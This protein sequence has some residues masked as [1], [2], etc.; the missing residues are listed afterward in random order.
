MGLGRKAI[1]EVVAM[2]WRINYANLFYKFKFPLRSDEAKLQIKIIYKS[3]S[4]SGVTVL[5]LLMM[6]F[7]H[8]I[9]ILTLVKFPC[10]NCAQQMIGIFKFIC[11]FFFW[12]L[13]H[14]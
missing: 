14:F 2:D 7:L 4:V 9:I 3:Q 6:F 1:A 13:L 8:F 12:I 10:F 11:C 5:E